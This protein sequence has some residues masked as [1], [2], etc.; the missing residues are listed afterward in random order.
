M[1]KNS[2]LTS[3]I[4]CFHRYYLVLHMDVLSVVFLGM[5]RVGS[6]QQKTDRLGW[7]I[8]VATSDF[9]SHC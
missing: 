6:S 5:A 1:Q 4:L 8:L 7:D 9:T 3:P 2:G